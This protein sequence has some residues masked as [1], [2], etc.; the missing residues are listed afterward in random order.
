MDDQY[1]NGKLAIED[2]TKACELSEWKHALYI[3]GLA[4][5]NAESGD[6]DSAIKW[7]LKAIELSST[8]VASR[9][10]NLELFRQHK[11]FRMTWR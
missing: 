7:E 2:A 11:P 4:L 5:A 9:Q 10:A 8:P 1:R 6:F 3:S